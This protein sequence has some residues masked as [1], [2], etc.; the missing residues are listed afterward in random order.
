MGILGQ[1]GLDALGFEPSW[2]QRFSYPYIPAPRLTHTTAQLVP[3]VS[4]CQEYLSVGIAIPFHLIHAFVESYKV[5][6]TKTQS[7]LYR[8]QKALSETPSLC[9]N[10]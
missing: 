10:Q 7:L 5:T 3:C 8:K 9:C 2:V 4:L 1:E 6:L